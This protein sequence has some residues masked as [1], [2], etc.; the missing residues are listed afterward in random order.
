MGHCT[1]FGSN[2]QEQMLKSVML[3]CQQLAVWYCGNQATTIQDRVSSSGRSDKPQDKPPA[4][5]VFDTSPANAMLVVWYIPRCFKPRHSIKGF[6][7]CI[8]VLCIS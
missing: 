1:A 7:D 8:N 2:I 4:Y 5:A 6:E 3:D